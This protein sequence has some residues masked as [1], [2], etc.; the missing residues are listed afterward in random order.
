MSYLEATYYKQ[1]LASL[2]STADICEILKH[3]KNDLEL[4]KCIDDIRFHGIQ[5]YGNNF[6]IRIEPNSEARNFRDRIWIT[7]LAIY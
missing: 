4:Q 6:N 5:T 3:C 1:K 2:T 7:R